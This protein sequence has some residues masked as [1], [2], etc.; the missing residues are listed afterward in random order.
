MANNVFQII[1]G[2]AVYLTVEAS[3]EGVEIRDF[4]DDSLFD[5]TQDEARQLGEWLIEASKL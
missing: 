2:N 5:M 1:D 4:E 3:S